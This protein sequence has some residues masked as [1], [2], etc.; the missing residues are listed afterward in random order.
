MIID[1]PFQVIK[2]KNTNL[3]YALLLVW[4]P[5]LVKSALG[6]PLLEDSA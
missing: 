3:N 1:I 2:K 4:H 6:V 5:D